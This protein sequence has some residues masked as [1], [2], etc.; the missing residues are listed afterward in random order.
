MGLVCRASRVGLSRL[1]QPTVLRCPRSVW[2][3]SQNSL[4]LAKMLQFIVSHSLLPNAADTLCGITA[5]SPSGAQALTKHTE[6]LRGTY[7][8]K[9]NMCGL[10]TVCT[11]AWLP[12]QG[13]IAE[14]SNKDTMNCKIG[15]MYHLRT[16]IKY[17][18]STNPF[19]SVFV[20]RIP[21]LETHSASETVDAED[22]LNH[23]RKGFHIT[24]FRPNGPTYLAHMDPKASHVP[25][26]T[27][28]ATEGSCACPN[29]ATA[30]RTAGTCTGRR[31]LGVRDP[32]NHKF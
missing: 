23:R 31:R 24:W 11:P 20:P 28:A 29:P 25:T 4:P 6:P 9:H 12:T 15:N 27:Q 10:P 18:L 21:F 22:G 17:I 19:N 2:K 3:T 32:M 13:P 1:S 30:I 5:L 7:L 8:S 26:T 14:A 16:P